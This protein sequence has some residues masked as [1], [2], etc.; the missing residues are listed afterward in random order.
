[1]TERL[2][3]GEG[4]GGVGHGDELLELID[5]EHE[6]RP[7]PEAL[8]DRVGD[9]ARVGPEAPH[10]RAVVHAEERRQGA[11]ER[12]QGRA[13][14]HEAHHRPVPPAAQRAVLYRRQHAGAAERRLAHA[15]V[16]G[17]DHQRLDAETLDERAGLGVPA[18][19]ERPVLG[20]EGVQAAV[21]VARRDGAGARGE[22]D[23][24]QR[25]AQLV[26]G[27][28]ALGGIATQAALHDG[29]ELGAHLGGDGRHERR[30]ALLHLQGERSRGQIAVRW[31][32]GAELEEERAPSA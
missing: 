23:L 16:A 27:G 8:A 12:E 13:A 6:A 21:G 29:R 19:E 17:D 32:A 31:A 20:L 24:L 4:A 18:E 3:H 22:G 15:G 7:F 26:A 30:V 28:E 2:A 11:A 1:M 9:R 25:L 10:H 14:G 5:E